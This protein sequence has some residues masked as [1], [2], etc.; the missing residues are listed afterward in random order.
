M[1]RWRRRWSSSTFTIIITIILVST[2][3]EPIRSRAGLF[4][5]NSVS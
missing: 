3:K 2:R 1:D 5:P 4:L